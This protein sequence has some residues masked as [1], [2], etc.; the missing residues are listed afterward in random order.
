M[1]HTNTV[2]DHREPITP[3]QK[4]SLV[5]APVVAIVAR[6]VWVPMDDDDM[7]QYMVELAK[8]PARANVGALLMMLSALLLVPAILELAAI[9]RHRR[10]ALAR[11]AAAM[12]ITGAFGMAALCTVT[13][14]AT[15][16]ARQ[17]DQAA[18]AALWEEA[19]NSTSGEFVFLAVLVGVVGFFVLSVGLYRSGDV[20]KPAAVLVGIGGATTLFTSGGPMRPLLITAA[21][22]ALVGFGWVA[23]TVSAQRTAAADSGT[24][25]GTVGTGALQLR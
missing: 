1:S 8:D 19:L 16:L 13:L 3:L 14:I 18:M 15:Q 23:F 10:P 25:A 7:T 4:L 11:V 21:A 17:P 12:T 5:A 6:F 2:A 24:V 22:L 9:V 20:P